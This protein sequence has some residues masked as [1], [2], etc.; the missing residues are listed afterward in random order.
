MSERDPARVAAVDQRL[1]DLNARLDKHLSA[2][3]RGDAVMGLIAAGLIAYE[4][5][6][7]RWELAAAW[8]VVFLLTIGSLF[9]GIV[10]KS[11][12]AE[13]RDLRARV[14]GPGEPADGTP[15]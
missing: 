3:L 13:I 5:N 11:C 1:A 6:I 12:R 8:S 2:I 4:A 9:Q 15:Y 7:G 10:L 14:P